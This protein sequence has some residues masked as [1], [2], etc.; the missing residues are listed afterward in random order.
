M[1][2]ALFRT[3]PH[4]SLFKKKKKKEKTGRAVFRNKQVFSILLNTCHPGQLL[5]HVSKCLLW[6]LQ[7]TV[8]AIAF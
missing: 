1:A 7:H 3:Q 5:S 4:Y 2:C 6:T 8:S